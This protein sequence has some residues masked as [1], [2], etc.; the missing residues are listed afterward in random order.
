MRKVKEINETEVRIDG[1]LYRKVE[2]TKTK[3]E[4]KVGDWIIGTEECS[5]PKEPSRV[6]SLAD[7]GINYL[8]EQ[9]REQFEHIQIRL[10]TKEEIETHL[11]KV[12]K[13]K[14]KNGNKL[15]SAK[16]DSCFIYDE[17]ESVDYNYKDDILS[18]RG[19]FIYYKGKWAEIIPEKKALP[20]TKEE[21]VGF[22]V[23]FET[24]YHNGTGLSIN[25]FLKEYED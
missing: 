19:M 25:E 5:Y 4:F 24:R 20:K 3:T 6:I 18:S 16:Y 14:Y 7:D 12:C 21:F 10:A 2:E 9:E 17:L 22:L 1:C 11:K 15:S 13:E 8:D 23:S